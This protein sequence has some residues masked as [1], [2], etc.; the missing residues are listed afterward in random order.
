MTLWRQSGTVWFGAVAAAGLALFTQILLARN[1]DDETFGA[2][3]NAYAIAM[4]VATFAFQG[5]GEVALR[6]LAAID[7]GRCVA[8]AGSLLLVGLIVST[9]WTTWTGEAGS[10]PGLLLAFVPFVIVH[11]GLTAGMI[12]FQ[13]DRRNIGIAFWP[14]GFQ[15]TRL[16]V[17]GLVIGAGGAV[18]AVPIGWFAALTPLAWIGLRRLRAAKAG[19]DRVATTSTAGLLRAALPFSATRLLEFAEIQLPVVLAMPL[20]G[21]A[22][23]GRIAACLA[24]VQGLLLLPISIFQ[25]LLRARFHDWS[26]ADPATLRRTGLLGAAAMALAGAALGLAIRPFASTILGAVFGGPFTAATGFLGSM[27]WLLP[28]WFASIAINATLVSPRLADLRFGCQAVGIVI[29]VGGSF[30]GGSG[31]DGIVTGMFASQTFLL[32][33]G[34]LLV[35]V[36]RSPAA[37]T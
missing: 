3:S 29:L 7:V 21:A 13:L 5:L 18:I 36:W 30:F 1:L 12:S 10:T 17:V 20:L 34:I 35:T 26:R 32:L 11:A 25:R 9:V 22:E 8:A 24:I 19:T 31:T 15:A 37:R 6:N 16:A 33:S 27:L 23:T 2:L 14:A 28:I 4:L